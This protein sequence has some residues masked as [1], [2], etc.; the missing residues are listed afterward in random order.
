MDDIKI[1]DGTISGQEIADIMNAIRGDVDVI[2]DDAP[3][4]IAVK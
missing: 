2:V 1:T 3:E 4:K